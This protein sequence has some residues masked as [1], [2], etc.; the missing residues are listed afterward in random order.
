[1]QP[2]TRRKQQR[3]IFLEA[4][5]ALPLKFML[6]AMVATVAGCVVLSVMQSKNLSEIVGDDEQCITQ[7]GKKLCINQFVPLD[8]AN[9]TSRMNNSFFRGSMIGISPYNRYFSI[10]TRFDSP[11]KNTTRDAKLSI[12]PEL[13]YNITVRGSEGDTIPAN[14]VVFQATQQRF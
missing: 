1:M 5:G 2:S 8:C 9:A 11:S 12:F 14:S 3:H 13:S 6:I 10:D 7:L 4:M